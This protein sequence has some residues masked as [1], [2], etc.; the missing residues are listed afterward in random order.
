MHMIVETIPPSILP[1]ASSGV[2]VLNNDENTIINNGDKIKID[3]AVNEIVFLS[4]HR[5]NIKIVINIVCMY[6]KPLPYS[7]GKIVPV[8][9]KMYKMPTSTKLR[10]AI[11]TLPLLVCNFGGV[12]CIFK[13]IKPH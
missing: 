12:A 11:I 5:N 10:A 2:F 8:A 7:T 6:M 1:Y 4:I 9:S 13:K 3:F